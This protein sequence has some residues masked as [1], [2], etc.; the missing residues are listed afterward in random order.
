MKKYYKIILDSM[1][2]TNDNMLRTSQCSEKYIKMVKCFL[3]K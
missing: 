2:E 3:I 1:K